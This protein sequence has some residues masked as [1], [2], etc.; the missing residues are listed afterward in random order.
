MNDSPSRERQTF[1]DGSTAERLGPLAL[2]KV[3]PNRGRRA[4]PQCLAADFVSE[5]NRVA[6]KLL[7]TDGEGFP[8]GALE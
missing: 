8:P 7:A 4:D 5:Q 3:I 6:R 2:W 1:V